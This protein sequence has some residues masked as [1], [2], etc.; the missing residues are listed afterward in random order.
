[1]LHKGLYDES[2]RSYE[3]FLGAYK[4][5]NYLKDSYY[6]M[7]IC[8]WLMDKENAAKTEFTIAKGI[9][10][11][12]TEA[13]R[14]AA[15]AL[16]EDQPPP[17]ALVK[18]RYFTDG[19]YYSQA[20]ELTRTMNS[21]SFTHKKEQVEFVYRQARL[22]HKMGDLPKAKTIYNDAIDLSANS[23]WYFAPNACL[24]LGYIALEEGR[25]REAKEMFQK[26]LSYRKH[27]Y[28]NSID[29]KARSALAQLKDRR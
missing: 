28:K 17:P 19:G 29:S 26:A 6:K 15:K 7:G 12:T 4:G 10:K 20:M 1:M 8:Y 23:E 9:G 11:E 27:E 13:D 5:Q 22:F 21:N 3:A 16:L 14:Y 2:I 24:Q 18:L 25:E